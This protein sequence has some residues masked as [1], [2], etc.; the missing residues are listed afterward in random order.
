MRCSKILLFQWPKKIIAVYDRGKLPIQALSRHSKET[1][2]LLPIS[3]ETAREFLCV[4]W[5]LAQNYVTAH[6][7]SP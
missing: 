4:L 5:T 6:T 1:L 3:S 2:I 7:L